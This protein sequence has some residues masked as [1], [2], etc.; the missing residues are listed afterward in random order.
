MK[1]QINIRYSTVLM[2]ILAP[3]DRRSK[4]QLIPKISS[5][6]DYADYLQWSA[7]SEG[8]SFPGLIVDLLY[9]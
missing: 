6:P 5:S 7:Y 2:A 1:M 9:A 4:S 3:N 8:T